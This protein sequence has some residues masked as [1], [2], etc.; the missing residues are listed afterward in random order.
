MKRNKAN[1]G[2]HFWVM[3]SVIMTSA[4]GAAIATNFAQGAVINAFLTQRGSFDLYQIFRAGSSI[5][6]LGAIAG[7]V[8]LALATRKRVERLVELKAIAFLHEALGRE[9]FPVD[10]RV[11]LAYVIQ[12]LQAREVTR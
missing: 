5:A 2:S 7:V 12:D 6:T 8:A 11:A 1:K 4:T 10:Q 9:G 3:F